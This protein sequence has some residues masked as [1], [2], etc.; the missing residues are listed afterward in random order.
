MIHPLRIT[1][2]AE[3]LGISRGTVYYLPQPGT[4]KRNPGQELSAD[5]MLRYFEPL[6]VNPTWEGF[7]VNWWYAAA[8]VGKP[9]KLIATVAVAPPPTIA[10]MRKEA[11]EVVCLY[12]P[13]FFMAVGQFFDDFS[14]V[15]DEQ[16]IAR[17]RDDAHNK[18]REAAA[19]CVETLETIAAIKAA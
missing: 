17:S 12:I 6:M 3:L 19:A 18:G 11:D 13:D 2:Q 14:Q 15:T 4:S 16:A 9:A 10:R 1:R 5:P 8:E 7:D